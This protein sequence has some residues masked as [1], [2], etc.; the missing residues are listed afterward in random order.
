MITAFEVFAFTWGAVWGSFLNVVIYR[1]PLDLSLVTPGSRCSACHTP[2]RWYDNIPVL[3][4]LVLRGRCRACGAAY[5]PRYML[6]EAATGVLTLVLFRAT[7]LPL[8]PDTFISGLW[9]W[10]WAQSFVYGLIALTF[11][12]L[13]H[14]ILPDEITIPLTAIGV[15]GAFVL[16]GID[17]LEHLMGA[18]IGALAL[19]FVFGLGWLMFR[20]E[21]MGLGDVKL[22]MLLGAFLGWRPLPFILFASATQALL[23]TAL[24][25]LISKITGRDNSLTM[26]TTELDARFGE[27]YGDAPPRMVI[28]Y[29][30]F[31]ALSGLEALLFGHA[32][33]WEWVARLSGGG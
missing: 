23:I 6:I 18:V 27:D 7:V 16:P 32:F 1:L 14:T 24:M 9:T 25:G 29:G 28:P 12:D 11:I 10:L 3:S 30:P 4:Y 21:A 26:T 22:V 8:D 13:E 33:F 19:L 17:G 20:R 31:L 2:I 15:F 5:S